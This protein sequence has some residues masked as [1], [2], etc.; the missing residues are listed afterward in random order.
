MQTQNPLGSPY[1]QSMLPQVAP[2]PAEL[3]LT[4]VLSVIRRHRLPIVWGCAAGI[5][6][7]VGITL[8]LPRD[9]S[10]TGSFV[11]QSTDGAAS[12]IS[13]LAAQFGLSV[14]SDQNPGDSPL[15][16]AEL[17]QSR[18]ILQPVVSTDYEDE[19]NKTHHTLIS[20]Y[21]ISADSLP[22]R[23][24]T[25][26]QILRDALQVSVN[27]ET[28]V[29][30]F[31]VRAPT[32]LLAAQVAS[33]I[34]VV[35]ND[36]NLRMRQ[37]M[38]QAERAF[39]LTRQTEAEGELRASEDALQR[40]LQNNLQYQGDPQLVFQHDRLQRQVD[41]RQQ[42]F[43]SLAQSYAQVSLSA[44]RN[45]PVIMI[46]EHPML[47]VHPD[48]RKLPLRAMLGGILGAV[49]GLLVGLMRLRRLSDSPSD[50]AHANYP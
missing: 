33:R 32:P 44:V 24:Y 25:A 49:A 50:Y 12:R 48:S 31:T 28:G 13:G 37:E 39:V 14:G 1:A 10:A 35:L 26:V 17:L 47:P 23:E 42:V 29:V 43:A 36:Y 18:E 4:D 8:L 3:S 20:I 27:K 22:Q 15:V 21:G 7:A 41:I 45:T 19:R 5:V 38:A 9:Y 40:F 30:H 16:Y 46:L 11:P 6:V 2:T 34:L